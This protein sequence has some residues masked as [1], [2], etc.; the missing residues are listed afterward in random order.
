M[1]DSRMKLEPGFMSSSKSQVSS[2]SGVTQTNDNKLRSTDGKNDNVNYNSN[3]DEEISSNNYAA[4][5]NAIHSSG[6]IP[7]IIFGT[8]TPLNHQL[9]D[10][11]YGGDPLQATPVISAHLLSTIAQTT[12]SSQQSQSNPVGG[13]YLNNNPNEETYD[14]PNFMLNT[15]ERDLLNCPNPSQLTSS[16]FNGTKN[17]NG[18]IDF[19]NSNGDPMNQTPSLTLQ[20]PSS[21]F[22]NKSIGDE[23]WFSPIQGAQVQAQLQSQSQSQSQS[24]AQSQAQVQ[25]QIHTQQQQQQRQQQS[26]SQSHSQAHHQPQSQLQSLA[27]P[28][29]QL[30]SQPQSQ[31]QTHTEVEVSD[32]SDKSPANDLALDS[33]NLYDDSSILEAARRRAD[34]TSLRE[35]AE[36]IKSFEKEASVLLQFNTKNQKP[37][38][39]VQLRMKKHSQIFALATMF[40]TIK[41]ADGEVCPRNTVYSKYSDICRD[42]GMEALCNAAF[43]KLIKVFHPGIKTRRLG[44]RGSSRYNYCGIEMIEK[45]QKA[46]Y[47]DLHKHSTGS[48]EADEYHDDDDGDDVDGDTPEDSEDVDRASK[49]TKE[50]QEVDANNSHQPSEKAESRQGTEEFS[51]ASTSNRSLDLNFDPSMLLPLSIA[52][53]ATAS[54]TFDY[55]PDNPAENGEVFSIEQAIKPLTRPLPREDE[56]VVDPRWTELFRKPSITLIFHTEFLTHL[57]TEVDFSPN[58][59]P[60][61]GAETNETYKELLN[62][63]CSAL[64]LF[65]EE[66]RYFR[67]QALLV[68]IKNYSCGGIL[69]EDQLRVFEADKEYLTPL[70]HACD[71][72]VLRCCLKLLLKITFQYVPQRVQTELENFEVQY[73]AFSNEL[74]L[75]K[76]SLKLSLIFGRCFLKVIKTMR[77]TVFFSSN[78]LRLVTKQNGDSKR[79]EAF[80]KEL[81]LFDFKKLLDNSPLMVADTGKKLARFYARNIKSIVKIIGKRNSDDIMYRNEVINHCARIFTMLCQDLPE[82]AP[83]EL[84]MIIDS[85]SSKIMREL[86]MNQNTDSFSAWWILFSWCNEHVLLMAEAGGF[87]TM[88]ERESI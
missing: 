50:K 51:E 32:T 72:E 13:L 28:H 22:S 6:N 15:P 60:I 23:H 17:T 53:P 1:L 18:Y 37:S 88:L 8:Y 54:P 79:K 64:N 42:C 46:S 68:K 27:Q 86:T 2:S 67:L 66:W 75:E 69:N 82:I 61:I 41:I 80:L 21:I 77:R 5:T 57:E 25:A 85:L 24:Q 39:T 81:M 83:K 76:A 71:R 3:M 36:E 34:A 33:L 73:L 19:E 52:F 48:Y 55:L 29:S 84:I 16:T 62:S 35:I 14:N 74:V 38:K 7:N 56:D 58:F 43:G 47:T 49:N 78:F 4:S 26:Q 65:F 30:Q 87:L 70:I 20:V 10:K 44:I 9:M 63:Y 59:E 45:S 11:Y 40:K 12:A 31:S